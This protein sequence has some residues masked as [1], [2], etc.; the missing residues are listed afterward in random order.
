MLYDPTSG[1]SRAY[2]VTRPGMFVAL[3]AQRN[4]ANC[5]IVCVPHA[6]THTSPYTDYGLGAHSGTD[7]RYF[8]NTSTWSDAG[9]G[10]SKAG[11]NIILLDY[12]AAEF[13]HNNHTTAAD[14]WTP[15]DI[16]YDH[17]TRLVLG[18]EA[19]GSLPWT[20]YM[21]E[22]CMYSGTISAGDRQTV[23]QEVA[24]YYFNLTVS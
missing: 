22:I 9:N 1:T 10:S 13:Y 5:G 23:M 21:H 11:P 6:L 4:A 24:D 18:E 12:Q 17:D 7:W 16:T 19:E 2:M 15:A 8:I 20:G 14:T 3:D